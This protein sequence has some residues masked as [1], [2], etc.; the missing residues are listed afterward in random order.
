[1]V[2]SFAILLIL[3]GLGIM[4]F[5]LLMFYAWLPL[6]YGFLGFDVGLLLGRWMTGDFGVIAF[7]LGLAAA[8][9]AAGAAY[10][11]EPYRRALA[12]FMGGAVLALTI[13][14]VLRLDRLVS[15]FSGIAVAAVG[16]LA[17]AAVAQRY[18]DL[19]IIAA[20]AFGGAALI[21]TGGQLLLPALV[22]SSGSFLPALLT[23]ILGIFGLRWQ[24][25]NI[26]SWVPAQP[27]AGDPFAEQ[28]GKQADVRNS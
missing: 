25:G 3:C 8:V 17:G 16:G 5:G 12:G 10:V 14:S 24:L 11:L 1:M 2:L 22:G 28:V 21:V 13:L 9:G 4:G 15:G 20:S 6:F 18:F 26:A 27:A 7:T 19:F 23:A